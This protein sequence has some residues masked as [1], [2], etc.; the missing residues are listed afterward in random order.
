MRVLLAVDSGGTKCQAIAVGEDGSL[1][2]CGH[3]GYS[4]P[5]SAKSNF[6]GSGRSQESA[7]SA[8]RQALRGVRFSELHMVGYHRHW[9]LDG[10][11]DSRLP[12]QVLFHPAGEHEGVL[13]LAGLKWG[14]IASA[15][16]GAFVHV[17]TE[18]GRELHLDGLG[19]ILGDCGSAYQIGMLAVQAAAKCD[20]HPRHKTSL[21]GVVHQALQ[22]TEDRGHGASLIGVF[23]HHS[24]R[25][26][27]ASLAKLVDAEAERG[28]AIARAIIEQAAGGL[29][30]TVFDAYDRMELRGHAC[31][32]AGTGSVIEK[33][34]IYRER[35]SQHLGEIAPDLSIV[36]TE[37]PHVVGTALSALDKIVKGDLAA[38][39]EKLMQEAKEEL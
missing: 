8:I 6:G 34:A 29:A 25:A 11:F 12:G 15:G 10:I 14:V 20:W 22:R 3:S 17:I 30:E 36:W 24:D 38:A 26:V 2:G 1:L 5:S 9:S 23:E 13:E 19:P 27:I 18:D 16:T 39:R 21:K 37:L 4:G 7:T 35:F 32:L 31:G 33:S 28:D